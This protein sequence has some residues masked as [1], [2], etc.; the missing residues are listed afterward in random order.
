MESPPRFENNYLM[1]EYFF[2]CRQH[3]GAAGAP[4]NFPYL[5]VIKDDIISKVNFGGP[6]CAPDFPPPLKENFKPANRASDG[7]GRASSISV[8]HW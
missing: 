7:P 5:E 1:T 8:C 3:A 2:G 6:K 4:V